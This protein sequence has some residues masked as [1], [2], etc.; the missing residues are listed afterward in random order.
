MN[1]EAEKIFKQWLKNERATI[2]KNFGSSRGPFERGLRT[3]LTRVEQAF[4][5]AKRGELADF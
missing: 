2:K 5:A 4:I 1:D 3:E